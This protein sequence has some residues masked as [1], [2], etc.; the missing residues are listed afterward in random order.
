M[1][2]PTSSNRAVLCPLES[3]TGS[4]VFGSASVAGVIVVMGSSR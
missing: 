4:S 3:M 1:P 2:Y